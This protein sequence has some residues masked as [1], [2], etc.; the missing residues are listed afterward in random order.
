MQRPGK[1]HK[2]AMGSDARDMALY[3]FFKTAREILEK[4][5]NE[6]AAFYFEQMQDHLKEGKSLPSERR[7]IQRLLGI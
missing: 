3:N 4:E 1:T 2:A 6:D 5:G 7:E